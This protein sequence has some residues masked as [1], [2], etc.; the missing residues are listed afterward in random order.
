M[1]EKETSNIDT[2]TY[3]F[4]Y[5]SVIFNIN[6]NNVYDTEIC[7]VICLIIFM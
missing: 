4:S 7:L 5:F 6:N 1:S 2:L 3:V